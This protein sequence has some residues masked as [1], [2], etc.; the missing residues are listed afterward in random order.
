MYVLELVLVLQTFCVMMPLV[1]VLIVFGTETIFILR[2][3]ITTKTPVVDW[4]FWQNGK[5][6][7]FM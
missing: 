2:F 7:I 1:L 6:S 4:T 3:G 5:S